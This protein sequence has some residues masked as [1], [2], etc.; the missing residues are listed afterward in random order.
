M[1]NDD[2]LVVLGESESYQP[3]CRKCYLRNT[4]KV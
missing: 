1:T 2:K 4:N 3:L